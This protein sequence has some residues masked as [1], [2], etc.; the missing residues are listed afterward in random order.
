YTI[1][2]FFLSCFLT[3]IIWAQSTSVVYTHR[4]YTVRDGLPDILVTSLFQD[5]QGNLWVGTKSS[6]AKFDGKHFTTFDANEGLTQG[7]NNI[8]QLSDGRMLV[9]TYSGIQYISG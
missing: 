1:Q 6:L 7:I 9:C 3:G 4:L 5:R 2:L 8:F